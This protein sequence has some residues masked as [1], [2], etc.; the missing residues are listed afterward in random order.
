MTKPFKSF[1]LAPYP[2]G[3]VMQYFGENPKLYASLGLPGG[4]NGID[5]VGAWGTPIFAVEG[6]KVVESWDN[7]NAGKQVGILTDKGLEWEY[8]HLSRIDVALGTIV[9]E[10]DQIGLMGNTGFVVTGSTPYWASNPYAGT[11]LHL[12]CRPTKPFTGSGTWNVS[13]PDG[14]RA[15]LLYY[16]NGTKGAVDPVPYFANLPSEGNPPQY[17]T[18]ISLLNTAIGL[19][20]RLISA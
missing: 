15:E 20:R 11:H 4:H 6:G 12:Q 9:Q 19:Y 1:V 18:L 13:Y 8:D 7:G 10:G 17:L 14:T 3:N 5:L 16:E 2:D